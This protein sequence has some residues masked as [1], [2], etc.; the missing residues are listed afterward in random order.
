MAEPATIFDEE[1]T[2]AE[3]RAIQEAEADIAAGRVVPHAEVVKWLESWGTS[4]ELPRS[5]PSSP[6]RKRGSRVTS[7]GFPRSRE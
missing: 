2:E 6:P 1:D 3:E 4:G 5:S 7:A